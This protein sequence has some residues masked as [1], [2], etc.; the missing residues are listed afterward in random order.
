MTLARSLEKTAGGQDTSWS[1][2]KKQNAAQV[3]RANLGEET[4]KGM[5][6]QLCAGSG[7]A[8]GVFSRGQALTETLGQ[9]TR[10]RASAHSPAASCTVRRSGC[11]SCGSCSRSKNHHR[12]SFF[13]ANPVL[14]P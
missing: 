2:G 11:L 14:S 10:S 6:A 1:S 4:S 12:P 8:S 3:V 9:E 7:E 5:W 13:P